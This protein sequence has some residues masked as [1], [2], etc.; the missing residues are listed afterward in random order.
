MAVVI[1]VVVI[2]M[3]LALLGFELSVRIVRQ[4]EQGVLFRLGGCAARGH[5]GST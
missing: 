3:L 4:Y 5:R 2:V 1:A